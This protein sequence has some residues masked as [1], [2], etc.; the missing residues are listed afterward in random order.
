MDEDRLNDQVVF[1]LMTK[2]CYFKISK[3]VLKAA[4]FIAV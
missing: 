1:A 3:Q 2:K 4:V